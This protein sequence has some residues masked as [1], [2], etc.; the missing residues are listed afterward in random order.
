MA[1][2][3]QTDKATVSI[4]KTPNVRT[5]LNNKHNH[6]DIPSLASCCGKRKILKCVPIIMTIILLDVVPSYSSWPSFDVRL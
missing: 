6:N 5:E 2:V 3:Q 1:L 4:S